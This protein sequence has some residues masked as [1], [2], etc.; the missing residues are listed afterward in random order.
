MSDKKR[1][2][3]GWQQMSYGNQPFAYMPECH[4]DECM[5]WGD[6]GCVVVTLASEAAFALERLAEP[7]RRP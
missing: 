5:W 6:G 1:C 4:G 3:M 2:P 7:A